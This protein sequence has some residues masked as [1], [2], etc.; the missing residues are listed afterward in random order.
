MAIFYAVCCLLFSGFN[1]FAFKCFAG[2]PSSRGFFVLVCGLVWML[3]MMLIPA[4]WGTN[5]T[6]TLLTGSI[7]GIF[8]LLG[9]ILL[10]ESMARQNVGVCS[11]I[12][13]LNLILVIPLAVIFLG[14]KINVFQ[15]T[16]I[17]FALGAI[18]GFLPSSRQQAENKA[19][20]KLGMTLVITASVLRA[21]MG[22]SYKYGFSCGADPQ[23]VTVCNAVCWIAGGALY[24]VFREKVYRIDRPTWKAGVLSGVLICGIVF[25]MA[26]MLQAGNA[27][28]TLPIAQM[29]FLLTFVLGAVFLKEKCPRRT[30]L[31]AAAGTA[32]VLL[33][34]VS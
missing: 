26:K 22:I 32:A 27:S 3:I 28:I 29:S 31:S 7:S 34:S 16:G 6:A 4:N 23:A 13:R 5:L 12:Y 24:A 9:N 33:L 20:Q 18:I 30:I 25:F 14:E 21:L 10:I 2:K 17:L 19:A 8:S 11:T 15:L 1:D